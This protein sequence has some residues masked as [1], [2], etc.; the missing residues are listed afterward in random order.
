MKKLTIALLAFGCAA[1]HAQ[2]KQTWS[3]YLLDQNF[4]SRTMDTA[5]TPNG[6]TLVLSKM[7]DSDL[8]VTRYDGF[9]GKMWSERLGVQVHASSPLHMTSD[10][11]GCTLVTYAISNGMPRLTKLSET[12]THLWTIDLPYLMRMEK[13]A[14][15]SQDNAV[16]LAY[17]PITGGYGAIVQKVSKA[18]VSMFKTSTTEH[19]YNPSSLAVA[20]NGNIYFSTVK[21]NTSNMV[22]ALTPNGTVRYSKSWTNLNAAGTHSLPTEVAAD[23]NGRLVT[24]EIKTIEPETVLMRT[25]DSQGNYVTNTEDFEFGAYGIK[26]KFDAN[27]KVVLARTTR[28]GASGAF[29][30]TADWYEVDD[31]GLENVRGISF[32]SANSAQMKDIFS[33]HFGQTYVAAIQSVPTKKAKIYALDES[34][35]TPRWEY[36]DGSGFA[37]FGEAFGAVGRWGQVAL[38]STVGNPY[39]V[40]GA[41]GIKQMGLR[42]LTI[43]GASF[44]GGRTITGT[45]NFYGSDYV[46]RAVTLASNTPFAL[47]NPIATVT[48]G[49]SQAAMSIELKPTNVRRAVA[50]EGRHNGILRQAVFYIE[51]PVPASVTLFPSTVKGGKN[52]NATAR[53]NGVAPDQGS[54]VSLYSNNAAATLPETIMVNAGAI[55]K[56]FVISTSAVS[57]TTQATISVTGNN[58]T[59]TAT[60]TITP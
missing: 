4:M 3:G 28:I 1:S 58:V 39:N 57:Q 30:I 9:G 53:L 50:I 14:V 22:W 17:G 5:V 45:I 52:V 37:E 49:Q 60:L 59:K 15:D 31:F 11:E 20:A 26:L 25:F 18:G 34:S 6:A 35:E 41:N 43:N 8:R 2:I 23:R 7:S 13:I 32:G 16:I 44:T 36:T 56:G 55:T 24:A 19:A 46:D 47:I 27:G 29:F 38:A 42:N 21:Y 12:G 54:W 51:P 10:S 33:D 40:E 48:T